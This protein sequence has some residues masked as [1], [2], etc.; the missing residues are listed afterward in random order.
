MVGSSGSREVSSSGAIDGGRF[1]PGT[2]LDARYRIVGLLGRGGMGEVYR[3]DD[4][5]LGEPVAIKLLPP[6]LVADEAALSR[7]HAEVRLARRITHPNVVRVHDVGEIDGVPYLTMEYVSG[8]DLS[9]LLRRIGR[10][11]DDKALEL[12]HQLCAGVAAAHESD[13]LHRDLKP[14]N[15]MIDQNG[16][17]K[18]ADF[19]LA[20][21]AGEFRGGEPVAGT[22]AYMAPEQL[23]GGEVSEQTDLFALGLVFY[24]MFTGRRVFGDEV[25]RRRLVEQT[26]AED[27]SRSLSV[28]GLGSETE[29]VLRRCVAADPG[30]R[31]GSALEISAALPGGD[32]LALALAAGETPSPEVVAAAPRKGRLRPAVGGA[33]L[34]AVALLAAAGL[35]LRQEVMLVSLVDLPNS[36]EV[37]EDRARTMIADLGYDAESLHV[38]SGWRMNTDLLRHLWRDGA[39]EVEGLAAHRPAGL[40]FV[41]RQS[42]RPFRSRSFGRWEASVDDELFAAP[43]TAELVL[44]PAGRLIRL[45]V[46]PDAREGGG[47]TSAPA[48][49]E[50][51]LAASGFEWESL[52]SVAPRSGPALAVDRRLAWEG[53]PEGW[54]GGP[55]YVVADFVDGRPVRFEVSPPWQAAGGGRDADPGPRAPDVIYTVLWLAALTVGVG[56]A[57]THLREGRADLRGGSR[58][59]FFMI[60][61]ALLRW[62]FGVPDLGE[63]VSLQAFLETL[64][65][66]LLGGAFFWIVYTAFEPF[67]RRRWPD[68]VV[69]WTRLLA[70]R[71][72]DPLVGRDVLIGTVAGSAAAALVMVHGEILR[73]LGHLALGADPHWGLSLG[74]LRSVLATL[75]GYTAWRAV[76]I[77]LGGIFSFVL[78]FALLRRKA[79]ATAANFLL[80][81]LFLGAVASSGVMPGFSP[82]LPILLGAIMTVVTARIGALALVVHW[83]VF[84]VLLYL[85]TSLDLSAWHSSG[86]TAAAAVTLGLGCWG[87]WSAT[88]RRRGASL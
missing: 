29:A 74:G 59:A 78:F 64:A 49:E 34:L 73:Q 17:A 37:L 68:G 35:W 4:L 52:T 36:G 67:L 19:G 40:W 21:L 33:L 66:A 83:Y 72:G 42:P 79:L 28:D 2:L 13:V 1:A 69:S 57:R 56:L 43:G 75:A 45:Q 80:W 9:A 44:D 5:T 60:A 14:A 24:E 26:T 25:A 62:I 81:T 18:I 31:P 58:L 76:F 39:D 15:V 10:L 71:L 54:L 88:D 38:A 41:Y 20:R 61:S 27:V 86:T 32:P 47:S 8:E 77:G 82:V 11:P 85:P 6:E 12:A 51:L 63:L 65:L 16:R 55:L 46:E 87:W 7:F 48:S 22:P 23:A 3:A 30:D 53:T 84:F 70:G 50:A